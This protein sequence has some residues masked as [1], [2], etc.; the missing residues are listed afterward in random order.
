[1]ALLRCRQRKGIRGE[2]P[3]ATSPHEH[4]TEALP[5]PFFL[6]QSTPLPVSTGRAVDFLATSRPTAVKAFWPNQLARLGR[7]CDAQRDLTAQWDACRPEAPKPHE[8]CE[9]ALVSF[10]RPSIRTWGKTMD[11]TGDF[12]IFHCGLTIAGFDLSRRRESAHPL[13]DWV[14]SLIH[15]PLALLSAPR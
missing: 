15:S 8:I 6:A 11:Q 1:M 5:A 2:R 12:W 3:N 4:I 7:I 14:S 9:R 10:S 13:W